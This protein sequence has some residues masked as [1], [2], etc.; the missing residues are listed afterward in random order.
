[1]RLNYKNQDD[2]SKQYIPVEFLQY[3]QTYGEY[4]MLFVVKVCVASVCAITENLVRNEIWNYLWNRTTLFRSV[5]EWIGWRRFLGSWGRRMFLG[6][7]AS[8]KAFYTHTHRNVR[9][10][11]MRIVDEIA[12][13][14]NN[15][16][17]F[18][19]LK[20][21]AWVAYDCSTLDDRGCV[22]GDLAVLV[23]GEKHRWLA[24]EA[25]DGNKRRWVGQRLGLGVE[26]AGWLAAEASSWRRIDQ[27]PPRGIESSR[28]HITHYRPRRTAPQ[29]SR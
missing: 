4:K 6:P 5:A 12:K 19:Q 3:M 15:L 25:G 24:E 29:R 21:L 14:L 17:P 10:V 26:V 22:G 2:F 11:H 28:G 27:P 7:R 20:Q 1:M 16:L 13:I 18:F 23:A 8:D 9:C